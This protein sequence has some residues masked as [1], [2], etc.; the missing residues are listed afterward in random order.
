M[1][2]IVSL[3]LSFLMVAALLPYNVWAMEL[4]EENE[5]EGEEIHECEIEGEHIH[6][7]EIMQEELI[8][9]EV[10]EEAENVLASNIVAFGDCSASGSSVKW[11]LDSNGVL[12]IYGSGAMKN[13]GYIATDSL[14]VTTAPWG[15][16][17]D[18][19]KRLKIE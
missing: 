16:Y 6:E 13:Y 18:I 2:K 5:A 19:L 17:K 7:E 11:K 3:F 14:S 1:K 12:T 9:E 4:R 10:N 15:K 8:S